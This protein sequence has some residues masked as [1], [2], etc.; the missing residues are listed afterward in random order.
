MVC[1]FCK[2][3]KECVAVF[4]PESTIINVNLPIIQSPLPPTIEKKV[5]VPLFILHVLKCM[6]Q[7]KLV[8]NT[9][10][11]SRPLY[12]FN[13]MEDVEVQTWKYVD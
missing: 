4:A 6:M 10:I 7:R 9:S 11:Y 12:F 8:D 3:P 2:G 1:Q 13:V 5:A